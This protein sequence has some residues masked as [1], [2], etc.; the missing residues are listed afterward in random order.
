MGLRFRKSVKLCKGLKLNFG[1]TGISATVGSGAFKKTFHTSGNVTTTVGLPG[2]GIYW[3]ETKRHGMR[4]D[5]PTERGGEIKRREDPAATWPISQSVTS[6]E[7]TASVMELT[8][9][10]INRIYAY[11]DEPVEWTELI[12]GAT[13]E[14][15]FMDREK[16]DYC[17]GVAPLILAGNVDAYLNAI[18]ILRP[19]DDLALYGGD[20][21]FGTDD[22]GTMEVEF[23]LKHQSIFRE[24]NTDLLKQFLCAVSIRTARDMCA[25]LPVNTVLVHAVIGGVTV[26]SVRFVRNRM[27]QINFKIRNAYDIVKEFE[28]RC[29]ADFSRIYDVGRLEA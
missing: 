22:P 10:E 3:T 5:E 25:L 27:F 2:T 9:A 17:M 19:V 11:C 13:A 23:S 6:E 15:L 18:E 16:Y 12:S 14:E 28:H 1:K 20:F 4:L 8:P 24:M 21:E 7:Q 26:L 29:V